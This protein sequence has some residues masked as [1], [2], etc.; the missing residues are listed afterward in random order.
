MANPVRLLILL[1]DD[2]TERMDLPLVPNSVEELI[3]Q[4]KEAWQLTGDIRLQYKDVD[5]GTFVNLRSTSSIKDL[6]TIKR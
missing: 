3:E 1:S 4:I 2:S 5:F 6:T